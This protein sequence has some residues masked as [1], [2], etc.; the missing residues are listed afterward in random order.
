MGR[1]LRQAAGGVVYHVLNRRV[2]R[3]RLFDDA[4]DY[5]AFVRVLEEAL[6][7]ADAPE[8]F[9]YCL[10]PNH[11][12]LLLRPVRDGDLPRWMQW[13]TVTHTHRWH[14]HHHTAGTG[15]V[16][17]G[18]FKS[19][20][21]QMD[22]HFLTVAR[23]IERNPLRAG[24]V[25][26]AQDWRWS[27][28]GLRAARKPVPEEVRLR[29]LLGAW[30]TAGAPGRGAPGSGRRNPGDR[31]PG[32]GQWLRWVNGVETAAELEA[33]RH[34]VRRGTP[35]GTDRWVGG[36]VARLELQSTVRPRGRP[37]KRKGG[38]K[39]EAQHRG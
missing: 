21:V 30:P 39:S 6:Q 28:L 34:S 4:G 17:Q 3:L 1:P 9:S 2:L 11:W 27:S 13:L 36:T 37:K 8:L 12:H 33:L 23:Y 16:Y 25:E 29:G 38:I 10:M 26:R 24:L 32:A 35:F 20:P 31:N 19:F 18:R 7:R 22:G 14:G 15:P 5:L